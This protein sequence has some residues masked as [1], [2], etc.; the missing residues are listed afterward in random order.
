MSVHIIPREE[1]GERRRKMLKTFYF[2]PLLWCYSV[3]NGFSASTSGV[4]GGEVG[5]GTRKLFDL[6]WCV[7]AFCILPALQGFNLVVNEPYLEHLLGLLFSAD[8]S[9]SYFFCAYGNFIYN[10][11]CL[12]VLL[13]FFD[14]L[15]YEQSK[16]FTCLID[17]Y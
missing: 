6:R 17:K 11:V 1:K 8:V 10:S 15:V 2:A 4:L 16:D 7:V 13:L 12:D 9:D 5:K 3:E 14:L